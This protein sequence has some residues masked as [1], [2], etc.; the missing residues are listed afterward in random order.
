M[1]SPTA[2]GQ[3]AGSEQPTGMGG[4]DGVGIARRMMLATQS[5]AAAA[6]AAIQ[7]ASRSGG[8]SAESKAWWKLLPKPALFDHAT[9]EAEIAGWKDW[10][11]SF[12]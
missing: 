7:A 11:W 1:G 12:E 3:A 10:S 5:A 4:L 8:S 2:H 6:Q 9:R